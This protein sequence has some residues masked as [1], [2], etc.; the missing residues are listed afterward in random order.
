MKIRILTNFVVPII[1]LFVIFSLTSCSK[2]NDQAKPD[3][4]AHN[5]Q[6]TKKDK[7]PQKPQASENPEAKT[8]HIDESTAISFKG[9]PDGFPVE[10]I[11]P[12]PD[13]EVERSALTDGRGTLL[14]T[15]SDS[16]EK[17]LAYYENFYKEK[18]FRQNKP[19]TVMGRIM[20]GFDSDDEG[21]SMTLQVRDDGKTFFSLAN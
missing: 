14:Q 20:L 9:M 7:M 1:A 21:I 8:I 16:P 10:L 19:V 11:P 15:S 5:E 12:Y 13:G 2:K 3:A 4:T 18:G 6:H 17:V